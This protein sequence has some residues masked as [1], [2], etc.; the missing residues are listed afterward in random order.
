MAMLGKRYTCQE[1]GAQVLCT[2]AGDG[3]PNC[4][5]QEMTVQ[6]P[7]TLPSSD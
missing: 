6:E 7:K 2:K 5:G 1:C 3:A 4:C